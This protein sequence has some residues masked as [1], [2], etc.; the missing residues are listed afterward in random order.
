MVLKSVLVTGASGMVGWHALKIL[1][2]NKIAAIATSRTRPRFVRSDKEW[3]GWDLLNWLSPSELDRLF[4]GVQA[5]LHLG[6]FVPKTIEDSS[7]YEKIFDINMRACLCLAEWALEKNITVVFLSSATIYAETEKRNI[8]EEDEKTKGTFG[9]FYGYSKLLAEQILQYFVEKGLRLVIL[10][11]SSLY[12][13]GLPRSKM[14]TDFLYRASRNET[15]VLKPPVHDQLNLI[16]A[17]D[18]VIAAIQ[19]L[20]HDVCGI[21]NV[22]YNRLYTIWDVATLACQVA[23]Q[24]SVEVMPC[25]QNEVPIIR[26]D[27]N[28]DR[29]KKAFMFDPQIDLKKGMAMMWDA[30]IQG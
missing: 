9:G 30:M 4:P 26:F 11:P 18:V 29:A 3:R 24:G 5:V 17:C 13:F 14:V 15:I 1:E 2:D 27:L 10:R 23:G 7:Q 19:A 12:G 16:H 22:A 21:Y 8:S 28:C 20:E 6:A 25:A